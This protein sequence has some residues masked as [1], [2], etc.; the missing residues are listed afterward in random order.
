MDFSAFV[1]ELD[2]REMEF[3]VFSSLMGGPGSV[4]NGLYVIDIIDLKCDSYQVK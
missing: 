1:D 4:D 2:L 3:G